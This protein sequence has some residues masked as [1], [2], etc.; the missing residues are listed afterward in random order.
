MSQSA[1]RMFC[2]DRFKPLNPTRLAVAIERHREGERDD[3]YKITTTSLGMEVSQ[4]KRP[5]QTREPEHKW[6]IDSKQ[7]KKGCQCT[8][9]FHPWCCNGAREEKWRD[10]QLTIMEATR[11]K[12]IQ[13]TATQSHKHTTDHNADNGNASRF[14]R[15][16]EQPTKISQIQAHPPM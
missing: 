3:Q 16:S 9:H 6:T 1:A 14:D 12:H 7:C 8:Y 4:Y 10:A 5:G 11:A 2:E 15:S 13:P